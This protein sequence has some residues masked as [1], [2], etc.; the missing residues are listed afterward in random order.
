MMLNLFPFIL[1]H[2]LSFFISWGHFSS[3]WFL[4]TYQTTAEMM[5]PSLCIFIKKTPTMLLLKELQHGEIYFCEPGQGTYFIWHKTFRITAWWRSR[6]TIGKSPLYRSRQ[7]LEIKF[8][9]FIL[10]GE[11]IV[12]LFFFLLINTSICTWRMYHWHVTA[13]VHFPRIL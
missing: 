10:E 7:K 9:V 4:T 13:I 6:K 5:S 8:C 2:N 12:E 1:S 11:N 3:Y